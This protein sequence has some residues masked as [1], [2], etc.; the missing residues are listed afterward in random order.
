MFFAALNTLHT[1]RRWF[2]RGKYM[3]AKAGSL[4]LSLGFRARER[5]LERVGESLVP[6]LERLAET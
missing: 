3:K 6:D 1:G 5:D 2:I 4:G